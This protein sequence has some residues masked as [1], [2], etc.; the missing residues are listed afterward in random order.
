MS[1]NCSF[2]LCQI[3]KNWAFPFS[4][5]ALVLLFLPLGTGL[6][7]PLFAAVILGSILSLTRLARPAPLPGP[8]AIPGWMIAAATAFVAA[9]VFRTIGLRQAIYIGCLIWLLQN[10]PFTFPRSSDF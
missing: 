7:R 4:F 2:G 5:A 6:A 1:T 9:I 8:W 10:E 3:R